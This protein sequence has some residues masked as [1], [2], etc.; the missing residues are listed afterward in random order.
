MATEERP[1]KMPA[2][3]RS[4]AAKRKRLEKIFE[5]RQQEGGGRGANDFDYV[6]DLLG[7]CVLGD[8]GNRDL[9]SRVSSKICRRST[10][11]TRRAARW[12]SSRSGAPAAP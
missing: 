6:T 5:D 3:S 11:T 4:L 8:P 9:R 10:A 2:A 7:Q 1:S 12:P